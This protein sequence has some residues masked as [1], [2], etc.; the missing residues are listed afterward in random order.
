MT[1]IP[2]NTGSRCKERIFLEGGA[3][4]MDEDLKAASAL[5][6]RLDEDGG[7]VEV[8]ENPFELASNGPATTKKGAVLLALAEWLGNGGS[9]ILAEDGVSKLPGV[10]NESFNAL[11]LVERIAESS[12]GVVDEEVTLVLMLGPLHCQLS[13]SGTQDPAIGSRHCDHH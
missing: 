12:R 9:T 4:V 1:E 3:A 5:G 6:A 11:T 13:L 10:V 8:E 2:D 7:T